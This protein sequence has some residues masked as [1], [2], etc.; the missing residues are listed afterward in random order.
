MAAIPVTQPARLCV[1]FRIEKG[2]IGM[3]FSILEQHAVYEGQHL[4]GMVR[5][6][7]ALT[8][9]R[10]LQVCHKQGGSDPFPCNIAHHERHAIRA[11][12]KKIVIISTHCSRLNADSS[13]IEPPS[14]G[15]PLGKQSRLDVLR[16]LQLLSGE[17]L[18]F[19]VL[20]FSLPPRLNRPCHLVEARQTE[21]VP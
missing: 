17:A 7:R 3:W 2:G 6:P 15:H 18:G 21:G 13:A 20:G 11:K 14:S 19:A 8:A 1:V 9:E 5:G 12:L 16:N 4:L 10:G